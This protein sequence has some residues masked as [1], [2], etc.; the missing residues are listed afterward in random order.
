MMAGRRDVPGAQEP[1]GGPGDRTPQ[2]SSVQL[3]VANRTFG[4]LDL[5]LLV[6]IIGLLV[7]MTLLV[8]LRDP[9]K[10]ND[11]I[12]Y[13]EYFQLTVDG[14]RGLRFEPVFFWITVV[15]SWVSR[16]VAVYL[17]VL[18][19]LFNGLI[20]ATFRWY[21]RWSGVRNSWTARDICLCGFMLISSWYLTSSTNGLR[22]GLALPLSYI[23][24]L[25]F[26]QRRWIW[27]AGAMLLAI[28]CHYSSLMILLFAP[29]IFLP[30]RVFYAVFTTAALSYPIGLGKAIFSYLGEALSINISKLF[31]DE[32]RV[33]DEYYGF[34]LQYYVY[35]IGM[36]LV[37]YLVSWL[38][39]PE[40]RERYLVVVRVYMLLLFPYLSF[41]FASYTNRYAMMAWL[42]IPIAQSVAMGLVPIK[43][44][45]KILIGMSMTVYGFIIFTRIFWMYYV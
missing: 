14:V 10:Y 3:P 15:I 25:A 35:S 31:Y 8:G 11:T 32:G 29:L 19:V 5:G 20:Y 7:L 33:V 45:L 40:S 16:N 17:T 13:T 2:G 36:A 42:F 4:A 26:R 23:S 38:I 18:Y 44:S 37:L 24:L 1:E 30:P 28:G 12:S 39:E 22:Q 21:A 43:D 41:A 27:A 34:N 6:W 9:H